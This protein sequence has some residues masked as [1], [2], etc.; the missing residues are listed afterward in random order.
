MAAGAGT[1][2]VGAAASETSRQL[3]TGTQQIGQGVGRGCS[4]IGECRRT[5]VVVDVHRV[6]GLHGLPD[7]VPVP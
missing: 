7:K 3:P 5:S 4:G 2:G 6:Q 1:A